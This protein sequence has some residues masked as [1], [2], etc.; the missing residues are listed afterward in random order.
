MNLSHDVSAI[1]ET[2]ENTAAET[3]IA[4][5]DDDVITTIM[6]IMMLYLKLSM[7]FTTL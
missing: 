1:A 6:L 7:P 5:T 2:A 4:V 3:K